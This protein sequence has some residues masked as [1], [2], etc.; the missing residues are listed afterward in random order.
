[1]A[2]DLNSLTISLFK[3]LNLGERN[4]ELDQLKGAL[5][6]LLSPQEDVH[7]DL[8]LSS[9]ADDKINVTTAELNKDV[10]QVRR[11]FF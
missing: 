7:C 5:A 8:T 2:S 10:E 3:E 11:G 6:R 1:M 9:K 4:V